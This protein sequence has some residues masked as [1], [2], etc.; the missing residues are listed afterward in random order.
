VKLRFRPRH[1][2]FE[3]SRVAPLRQHLERENRICLLTPVSELAISTPFRCRARGRSLV[4]RQRS[5]PDAVP[6][7]IP[8]CSTRRRPSVQRPQTFLVR[9]PPGVRDGFGKQGHT[10]RPTPGGLKASGAAERRSDAA[11]HGRDDAT[12]RNPPTLVRRQVVTMSRLESDGWGAVMGSI[13]GVENMSS[14][15]TNL[16]SGNIP[17]LACD[18]FCSPLHR[19]LAKVI[20]YNLHKL[21]VHRGLSVVLA[22]SN[23]DV[24]TDLRPHVLV[25]FDGTGHCCIEQHNWSCLVVCCST[26][27][28]SVTTR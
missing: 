21:V 10:P 19:R 27:L 9:G 16:S 28:V 3:W 4:P 26:A 7:F 20:S 18:E 15:G 14:C 1:G 8:R 5:F 12:A 6:V 23:E 25:R 22:C 13:V 2:G 17:L 24:V 11:L